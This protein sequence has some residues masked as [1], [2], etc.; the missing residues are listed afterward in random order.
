LTMEWFKVAANEMD[1]NCPPTI[2]L[3]SR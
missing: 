3:Q 2:P 1:L